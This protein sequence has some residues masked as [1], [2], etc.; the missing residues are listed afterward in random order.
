MEENI[1]IASREELEAL[2]T[3][4]IGKAI[5]TILE[6]A[7]R[8]EEDKK[9]ELEVYMALLQDKGVQPFKV[10]V[11]DG[12][13]H[14]RLKY[15]NEIFQWVDEMRKVLW[16]YTLL[17]H[18]TYEHYRRDFEFSPDAQPIPLAFHFMHIPKCEN[19]MP[20]G[21][22]EGFFSFSEDLEITYQEVEPIRMRLDNKLITVKSILRV[23]KTY[24]NPLELAGGI[25]AEILKQ[26]VEG[27]KS[28]SAYPHVF[29]SMMEYLRQLNPKYGYDDRG[30]K[31]LIGW[32]L[33]IKRFLSLPDIPN[34]PFAAEKKNQILKILEKYGI[35]PSD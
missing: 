13:Y 25:H 8:E 3:N 32:C 19:G 28:G 15:A 4:E 12:V 16:K 14:E 31:N 35:T 20:G 22:H 24:S 11:D 21:S 17:Y 27:I 2:L 1:T 29:R 26:V 18:L 23:C 34:F 5:E 6:D 7:E 10:S 33:D 9:L 30:P